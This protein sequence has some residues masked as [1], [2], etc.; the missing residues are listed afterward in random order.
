MAKSD[1]S[2]SIITGFSALKWANIG[3]IENLRL[4]SS[5]TAPTSGF[6]L[7][8]IPVFFFSLVSS[9]ATQELSRMNCE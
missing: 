7:H 6:Q 9:R 8:S 3:A 1:A 5:N 4:S 2:V